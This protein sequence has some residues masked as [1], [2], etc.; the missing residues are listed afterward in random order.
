DEGGD[1]GAGFAIDCM[2][3]VVED[4][5]TWT[6]FV[7]AAAADGV[8]SQSSQCG[9]GNLVLIKHDAVDSLGRPFFTLYAHLADGSISPE[10]PYRDRHDTAY[11]QWRRVKTGEYLGLAGSTGATE[12]AHPCIHLHFEVFRGAYFQN[13]VDPY[14]ISTDA[15]PR[16][17]SFYPGSVQFSSCGA[18]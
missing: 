11:D 13:P 7:V 18:N 3:G 2:R 16:T 17:R 5:S 1:R 9:Y 14:D 6:T 10:L 4:S 8:A 15:A 12:C